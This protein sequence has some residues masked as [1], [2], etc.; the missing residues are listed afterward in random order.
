[1]KSNDGPRFSFSAITV[2]AIAVVLVYGF[3][4]W[5]GA[6][7]KGLEKNPV[8]CSTATATSCQMGTYCKAASVSGQVSFDNPVTD[9]SVPNG[10]CA[11]IVY[12]ALDAATLKSAAGN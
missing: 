11:P 7:Q 1:M 6:I 8:A 5:Q 4:L 12:R 9:Q 10:T 2:L 3:V